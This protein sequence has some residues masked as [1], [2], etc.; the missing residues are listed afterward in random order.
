MIVSDIVSNVCVVVIDRSSKAAQLYQC[1]ETL[2][3]SHLTKVNTVEFLA[4][5][6]SKRYKL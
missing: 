3:Y 4:F 6:N 5:A 2:I 1:V